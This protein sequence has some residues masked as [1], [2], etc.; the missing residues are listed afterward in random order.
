MEKIKWH[1]DVDWDQIAKE[2]VL[3]M[4]EDMVKD[5]IITEEQYKLVKDGLMEPTKNVDI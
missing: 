3:I 4:F 2:V 5:G 1:D